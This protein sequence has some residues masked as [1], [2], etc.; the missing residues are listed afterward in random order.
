MNLRDYI[1][2]ALGL[3]LLYLVSIIQVIDHTVS[4]LVLKDRLDEFESRGVPRFPAS[5]TKPRTQQPL[6]K[7]NGQLERKRTA[8]D[9]GE[10]A[11]FINE[12]NT[13]TN[14]TSM[15]NS[16]YIVNPPPATLK[17][18]EFGN[19]DVLRSPTES[20]L[21]QYNKRWR[22]LN[23]KN[24]YLTDR[25]FASRT[26]CNLHLGSGNK[27]QDLPLQLSFAD[28]IE[29]GTEIFAGKYVSVLGPATSF[30]IAARAGFGD[31]LRHRVGV[32]VLHLGRGAAGPDLYQDSSVQSRRMRAIVAQSAVVVIVVMAGRSSPNSAFPAGGNAM[33]RGKGMMELYAVRQR[34]TPILAP[35]QRVT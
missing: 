3:L 15:P 24:F 20:A 28:A 22:S 35:R 16:P 13:T 10:D 31:L 25:C 33:D 14:G 12:L 30:G 26:V 9:A 7:Y 27:E 5:S 23:D 1:I 4:K 11:V 34:P 21:E 19:C 18:G 29:N 2:L 32:P 8:T 6:Q 17:L